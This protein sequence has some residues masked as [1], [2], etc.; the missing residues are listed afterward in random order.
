MSAT[1]APASS[2]VPGRTGKKATFANVLASEWTKLL[3]V[4]STFWT[5]LAGAIVVVGFSALW[6]LAFTSSYDQLSAS[7]RASLAPTSPMQIAFYF[8]EVIFGVLGVLVITAEYSTGMIRTALT[9]M[10]RRA[11]YLGAKAAVLGLVVLVAG[12]VVSFASF[13]VSQLILAG[14]DLDGSLGDPGVLRSVIGGGVWLAL[15][16]VMAL[17]IGTLL[18]HTAG[19]VVTVFVVLFVL[20]I[21]GGFLPGRWGDTVNKLLPSN[22]GGAILSPRKEAGQLGPWEGLGLFALYTLI[23]LAVALVLFERRDA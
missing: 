19:S 20:G 2:R 3:T 11:R 18:R 17:G 15:I 5:L 23:V 13:F 10:P 21:V 8:G 9:A 12:V 16:A 22:A 4:R 1:V 7:D 6:A 14:K